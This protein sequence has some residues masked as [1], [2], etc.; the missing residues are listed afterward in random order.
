MDSVAVVDARQ[1]EVTIWTVFVGSRQSNPFSRLS[2]AWVLTPSELVELHVWSSV[3]TIVWLGDST[4]QPV[5]SLPPHLKAKTL[6]EIFNDLTHEVNRLNTVYETQQLVAGK[7]AKLVPPRWPT[8]APPPS[9]DEISSDTAAS[10]ELV[11][12]AARWVAYAAD[13]WDQIE[14][15]RLART[16]MRD[17]SGSS[18]RP[19]PWFVESGGSAESSTGNLGTIAAAS[20]SSNPKD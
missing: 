4:S 1:D 14:E 18:P 13:S 5:S 2:G 3:L 10:K 12:N 6:D 16:Y 15:I 20:H 17:E 19:V 8:I 9:N 11:L 7:K